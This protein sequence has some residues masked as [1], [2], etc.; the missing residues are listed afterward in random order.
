MDVA[1]FASSIGC[2]LN[3]NELEF[4][5][6]N[7]ESL[8]E[9]GYS[10][11]SD[12]SNA[13]RGS[14]EIAEE[15]FSVYEPSAGCMK[16]DKRSG[17]NFCSSRYKDVAQLR[18]RLLRTARKAARPFD[19]VTGDGTLSFGKIICERDVFQS[20]AG[21][22]SD[23]LPDEAYEIKDDGESNTILIE[24]AP[25]IAEELADMLK[26]ARNEQKK[27]SGRES[28]CLTGPDFEKIRIMLVEKYPFE[29]GFVTESL[30]LF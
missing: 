12:E 16:S 7:A 25:E 2:F 4:S 1:S 3:L 13:V 19:S 15:I 30:Q 22:L 20:V 18:L 5:E 17:M 14:R 8:R 21:L 28:G 9:R 10:L 24:T 29:K 26:D 23:E 11:E 27:D 6:N